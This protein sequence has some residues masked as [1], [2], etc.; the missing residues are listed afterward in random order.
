FKIVDEAARLVNKFN[1]YA[2]NLATGQLS[3]IDSNDINGGYSG[4]MPVFSLDKGR[5]LLADKVGNLTLINLV[6]NE[7]TDFAY[8]GDVQQ[9]ELYGDNLIVSEDTESSRIDGFGLASDEQQVVHLLQP[10]PSGLPPYLPR[11]GP[12]IAGG[13]LVWGNSSAPN[14]RLNV[15]KLDLKPEP[16][17]PLEGTPTIPVPAKHTAQFGPIASGGYLYWQECEIGNGSQRNCAVRGLN[18]ATGDMTNIVSGLNGRV[19]LAASGSRVVWNITPTTCSGP[20]ATLG[21]YTEDFGGAATAVV[22]GTTFRTSPA[23]AGH[24][25]AWSERDDNSVRVMVKDLATGDT[26]PVTQSGANEIFINS[27]QISD[28]YIAWAEVNTSI[29]AG[30]KSSVRVY[31]RKSGDLGTV[32]AFDY[33]R[34]NIRG[35]QFSLDGQRIAVKYADTFFVRDLLA[36]KQTDLSASS[37]VWALRL[38]GDA[39]VYAGSAIAPGPYS[40]PQGTGVYGIDLRQPDRVETLIAPQLNSSQSYEFTTLD[41]WLVFSDSQVQQPVLTVLPL[42]PSLKQ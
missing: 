10:D 14:P 40:G 39:L 9:V 23:I 3:N 4:F 13:W 12:T 35:L 17:T 21:I 5:V 36:D 16:Q 25:V 28:A 34:L 20:C 1:I 33:D 42:P 2:Y 27:V 29:L 7:R 11:Y 19:E 38:R 26:R 18:T 37:F 8:R 22:T 31:D 15:S 41:N 32:F 30:H 6:S 24:T